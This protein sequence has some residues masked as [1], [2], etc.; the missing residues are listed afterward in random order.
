M[1]EVVC[2][3]A[4]ASAGDDEAYLRSALPRRL[5]PLDVPRGTSGP[6]HTA[7][8]PATTRVTNNHATDVQTAT[9]TRAPRVTFRRPSRLRP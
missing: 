8:S 3:P 4:G 7:L 9:E 6:D 5:A 2:S 1:R